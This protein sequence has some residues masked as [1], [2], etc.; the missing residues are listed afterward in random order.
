[1]VAV[2][3]FLAFATANGANVLSQADYQGLSS[4][5][6][7]FI[8][9]IAN[10]IELNKAWRQGALGAYLLGEF[11]R[12]VGLRDARDDGQLSNL[13]DNF[14]S[15]YRGQKPNWIGTF[16]GTVNARTLTLSPAPL[17]MAEMVGV[18]IRGLIPSPNT[19]P[20]T[21]AYNSFSPVPIVTPDGQPLAKNSAKGICEFIFDGTNVQLVSGGALQVNWLAPPPGFFYAYA[22]PNNNFTNLGA[23][24][25][26]KLSAAIEQYDI[27]GWYDTST[28]RFQPNKPGF[29]FISG[30]CSFG[31]NTTGPSHALR[32]FL[33][34]TPSF[35]PDI[36]D[37][38]GTHYSSNA[39]GARSVVAGVT[40]LNGSSDFVEMFGFQDFVDSNSQRRASRLRFAGW[41]LGGPIQ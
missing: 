20:V 30:D 37:V 33:N 5:Q 17:S 38:P 16:G 12:T 23:G 31:S 10:S 21:L 14:V 8:A 4:R 6:T 39:N 34:G 3:E 26:T 15:T 7:G 35:H 25:Y 27:E 41:F 13:I 22:D 2:N 9:G 1:M 18:P 24:V 36:G 32:A 40:Y 11:I 19:G 28:S 29:Y